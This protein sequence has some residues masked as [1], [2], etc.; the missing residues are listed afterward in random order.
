MPPQ[1]GQARILRVEVILKK[2]LPSFSPESMVVN[3]SENS[4][5]Q[6]LAEAA[7]AAMVAAGD[8]FYYCDENSVDG[9]T[10]HFARAAVAGALLE[11]A[12]SLAEAERHHDD[13]GSIHLV[14][15]R[16]LAGEVY[17]EDA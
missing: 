1:V 7:K 13:L 8:G 17:R 10:E 6:R 3:M 14:A 16:H 4:L 9:D 15:L 12:A 2:V 5:P 11:L